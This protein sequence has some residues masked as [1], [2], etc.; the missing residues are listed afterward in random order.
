MK[1]RKERSPR[2]ERYGKK[3]AE[4]I[5]RD[6]FCDLIVVD[7]TGVWPSKSFFAFPMPQDLYWKYVCE[8]DGPESLDPLEAPHLP[9][10][11]TASELA[12]FMQYGIG[13]LLPSFYGEW[14]DGPDEEMLPNGV[15]AKMPK[16]ALRNLEIIT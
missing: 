9:I 11:F 1:R 12:A 13:A 2:M 3:V 6:Y 14:E 8:L 16:E 15:L 7:E 5:F 10:P 4:A